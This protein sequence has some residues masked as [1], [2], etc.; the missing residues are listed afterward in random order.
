M[1]KEN[2]TTQQNGSLAPTIFVVLGMT[3]DLGQ[4]KLLPA[5]YDLYTIGMMP[6]EFRV[7]G[8]AFTEMTSNDVVRFVQKSLKEDGRKESVVMDAF[9]NR[10]SFCQGRFENTQ[11]YECLALHL[12]NIDKSIGQCT[13][14][15]FHLAVPPTHYQTILKNLA[16]SKLTTPCSDESGWTRVIV[17]KPFGK[18]DT[19]AQELDELLGKL[20]KEE[21]IFRIDH[22]LAKET[23]QNILLFRFANTIFEPVWNNEYIEKIIVRLHETNDVSIRGKTY[24]NVGALRDVGQ[25]HMLQML[26]SVTMEH[27]G[28]IEVTK[29]RKERANVIKKLEV[30]KGKNVC[31]RAQYKGYEKVKGVEEGSQTETFFRIRANIKTSRW[32]GVEC[33]L[34]GGKAL[35]KKH[36]EIEVVFK[37]AAP[38]FCPG[39][40][41]HFNTVR[42]S[43]QPEEK[44]MVRFLAKRKGFNVEVEPK[45]LTFSYD[46]QDGVRRVNDY[47]KLIHD[48][49][50][51]DQTLF[52]STEEIYAQWEFVTPILN[53]WKEEDLHVYEKGNWPNL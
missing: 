32:K 5:L 6:K 20:F 27:P 4:K 33:I 45:D 28:E 30:A 53:A 36:T 52:T 48:C 21:Q 16:K 1:Q 26:A 25:N 51:G 42:F 46:Q 41:T 11:D 2:I 37:P 31:L 18:D 47:E 24:D 13:N 39:L 8:F 44:I 29:M 49:V 19:T 12:E 9:C 15:L 35:P 50:K 10:V 17:E 38:C 43:I 22:Y 23:L 14:K 3:G 34:E 40:S 7:V